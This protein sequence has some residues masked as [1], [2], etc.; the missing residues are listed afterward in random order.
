MR[1][2]TAVRILEVEVY[3]FNFTT[4]NAVIITTG[5]QSVIL[6]MALM[7]KVL[8]HI[9]GVYIAVQVQLT[10]TYSRFKEAKHYV[11]YVKHLNTYA[12]AACMH[13]YRIIKRNEQEDAYTKTESHNK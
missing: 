10:F 12:G 6:N 9:F 2:T 8:H 3:L 11:N 4:Y 1:V 5:L 13:R 7:K